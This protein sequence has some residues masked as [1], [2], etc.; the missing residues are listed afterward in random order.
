MFLVDPDIP[1]VRLEG[2]IEYISNE[3]NTPKQRVHGNVSHHAT[4]RRARQ[5]S[6]GGASDNQSRHQGTSQ[7][8]DARKESYNS[9]QTNGP[10][11]ANRDGI[12]HQPG[13]FSNPLG[14]FV[15]AR[16]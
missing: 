11:L 5:S 10:T 7:I 1:R 13:Q 16:L 3:G 12:L 6:L 4:Q 8:A 2:K 9:V 15:S 14:K